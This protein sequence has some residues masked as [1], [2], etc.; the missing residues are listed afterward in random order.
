MNR[1][2][3]TAYVGF[4]R[5]TEVSVRPIDCGAGAGLVPCMECGGDGDWSKFH[6][7]PHTLKPEDR[8]C[9]DCKG[10]GQVYVSI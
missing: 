5:N 4:T 10:T 6:P 9:V 8:K 7:E 2:A 3:M 1:G